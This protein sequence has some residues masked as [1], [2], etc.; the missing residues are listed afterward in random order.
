MAKSRQEMV[1]E[2]V[3]DL[4]DSVLSEGGEEFLRDILTGGWPGYDNLPDVD[5]EKEHAAQFGDR[6]SDHG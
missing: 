2:L 3:D 1:D 4:I 6:E 5:V